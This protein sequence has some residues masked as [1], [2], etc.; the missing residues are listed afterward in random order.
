MALYKGSARI[1]EIERKST[2]F[3]NRNDAEYNLIEKTL[4]DINK[5]A[6]LNQ[7]ITILGV[8]INTGFQSD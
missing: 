2:Q 6:G 4:N 7:L 8:Q 5:T 3:I 1:T